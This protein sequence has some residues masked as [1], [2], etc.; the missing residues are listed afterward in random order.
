MIRKSRGNPKTHQPRPVAG[1]AL[2]HYPIAC[3]AGSYPVSPLWEVTV[4]PES[5]P[6]T[7]MHDHDALEVGYCFSGSGVLVLEDRVLHFN[8]GNI[9]ILPSGMMHMSRGAAGQAARWSYF[10]VD[11]ALLLAGTPDADDMARI[12]V[13]AS[14]GFPV[15]LSQQKSAEL[16]QTVRQIVLELREKR[17]SYRYIVKGLAS[18]MMGQLIRL[19]R[20]LPPAG[21][22][23]ERKGLDRI[24][25]ALHHMANHYT[26]AMGVPELAALCNMSKTHFRRMFEAAIGTPVLRYLAELRSRMAAA[27]LAETD[28]PISLVAYE[29]GFESINT[30][31][32]QFRSTLELTPTQWRQVHRR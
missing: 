31:N 26:E 19:T 12:G 20:D 14:P 16:C 24:A 29:V 30:F 17:P 9:S 2:L 23:P 25:P 13:F 6:I 3:H 7:D 18:T 1:C 10:W 4:E 11:P 15:I 21:P 27:I 5:H 32:R 28:K 22:A 8:A